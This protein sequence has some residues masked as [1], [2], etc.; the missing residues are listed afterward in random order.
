MLIVDVSNV[1]CTQESTLKITSF[2]QTCHLKSPYGMFLCTSFPPKVCRKRIPKVCLFVVLFEFN[3]SSAL[4]LKYRT[5]IQ[6]IR[7]VLIIINIILSIIMYSNVLSFHALTSGVSACCHFINFLHLLLDS[8]AYIL[9]HTMYFSKT[10]K[11]AHKAPKKTASVTKCLL[12]QNT[13]HSSGHQ[14]TAGLS[15]KTRKNTT[16]S[17]S[18]L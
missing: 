14:H 6:S 8:H 7:N 17:L 18:L 16:T 5:M 4:I 1:A 12:P 9:S 2:G 13:A 15:N 10:T 11:Q 3:L